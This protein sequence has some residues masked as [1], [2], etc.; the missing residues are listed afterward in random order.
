M[1]IPFILACMG[2]ALLTTMALYF[3][4]K[5]GRGDDHK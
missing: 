3:L 2:V 1:N 4:A 5:W